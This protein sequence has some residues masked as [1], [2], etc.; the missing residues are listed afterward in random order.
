MNYKTK[1]LISRII[2]IVLVVA[3]I[4]GIVVSFL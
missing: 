2:I 3:M 1:K 4:A